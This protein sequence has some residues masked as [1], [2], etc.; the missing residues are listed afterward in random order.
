MVTDHGKDYV[1]FI[2]GVSPIHVSDLPSFFHGSDQRVSKLALECVWELDKAQFVLVNTVYELEAEAIEALRAKFHF[3]IYPIG[4]AI[5]IEDK[6]AKFS[7]ASQSTQASYLRWLDSQPEDS[8]LYISLGSF[9]SV[10]DAQMEEIIAGVRKSGARFL[11]VARGDSLER[12]IEKCGDFRGLVVPWCD[13]LR[14]LCHPSIGGLWTHCGWNSTLEGAFAGVPMLAF[15]I[16]FDQIP[17]AKQ[18]VEDWKVGWRVRSG[19]KGIGRAVTRDE[20]SEM[21]KRLMDPENGEGSE[22]RRRAREVGVLCRRAV[23]EGG[24]AQDNVDVLMKDMIHFA[25][26]IE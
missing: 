7:P 26:A 13:Q 18:I 3:P 2:P 12:V 25:K 15:P 10:P 5:P 9:L 23:E 20:I 1:D 22:I 19:G 8:V 17:N 24:S 16:Y 14:V 21:V 11:W 6:T 4:P